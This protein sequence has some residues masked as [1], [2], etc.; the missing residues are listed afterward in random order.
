MDKPDDAIEVYMFIG[1]GAFGSIL[2]IAFGV[3]LA[4]FLSRPKVKAAVEQS[5]RSI[6]QQN[7]RSEGG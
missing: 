7:S 2:T 3:T 6:E 5:S 4:W 1:F